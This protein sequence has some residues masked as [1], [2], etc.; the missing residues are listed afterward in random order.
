MEVTEYEENAFLHGKEHCLT[1]GAYGAHRRFASG[2]RHDRDRSRD[3]ELFVDPDRTRRAS[4]RSACRSVLGL[5]V[6]AHRPHSGDYGNE[7]VLRIDLGGESR[8]NHAD[9][10]CQNNGCGLDRRMAISADREE[11]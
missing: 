6:R 3:P 1:S 4:A 11:E 7:S 10:S 5:R 8:R 9:L 2:A